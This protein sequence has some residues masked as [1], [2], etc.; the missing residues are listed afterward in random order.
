[1]TAKVIPPTGEPIVIKARVES[2]RTLQLPFAG[3]TDGIY[4][5]VVSAD[6]PIVAGVR[7][8]QSVT[9]AAAPLTPAA[10]AAPANPAVPA[11]AE[12]P[13]QTGGDFTWN[14][15]ALALGTQTLVAVPAGPRPTL[16]L[17]NSTQEK[18][19][20][21]LVQ[22][23]QEP[24]K[25]ELG[26]RSSVVIE[27]GSGAKFSLADA[28]GVYGAITYQATARGSSFPVAPASRLGS[29]IT[30]YSH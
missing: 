15:S 13:S 12:A 28:A 27:V 10:P 3:L 14:A 25:I 2:R 6:V 30:I 23:G 21:T 29:A 5:V 24:R 9:A 11:P 22:Q 4:T 26:A 18:G 16:T 17:F 7:T 20:V 19:A 1:V 8:V